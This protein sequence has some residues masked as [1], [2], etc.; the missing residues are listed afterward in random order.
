MTAFQVGDRVRKPS[1]AYAFDSHVVAVFTNRAGETRL[2]CESTQIPGLLHIFSPSQMTHATPEFNPLTGPIV[3]GDFNGPHGP[4]KAQTC[5]DC[6]GRG[7][8]S[9]ISCSGKDCSWCCPSC[10]GTG[11]VAR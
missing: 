9:D 1:G 5:P 4:I 2:V 3:E 10:N 6:K 8:E 11:K 7:G